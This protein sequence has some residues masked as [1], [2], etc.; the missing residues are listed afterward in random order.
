MQ[1]TSEGQEI[2]CHKQP[3]KNTYIALVDYQILRLNYK[4]N[5]SN[6][7]YTYV[8]THSYSSGA[9]NIIAGTA[10]MFNAPEVHSRQC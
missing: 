7:F 1:V 5:Q 9:L 3:R 6:Q 8:H 4:S 2:Y 10:I